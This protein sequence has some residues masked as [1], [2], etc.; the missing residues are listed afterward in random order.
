MIK[1]PQWRKR[2]CT[3]RTSQFRELQKIKNIEELSFGSVLHCLDNFPMDGHTSIGPRTLNPIIGLNKFKLYIKNIEFPTES[4]RDVAPLVTKQDDHYIC[5][6]DDRVAGLSTGYDATC[7]VVQFHSGYAG[8]SNGS[9]CR[10]LQ[11]VVPCSCSGYATET[12]FHEHALGDDHQ[13]DRS[14]S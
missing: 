11:P 8:S 3:W 9:G 14:G 2:F 5:W 6:C 1:W 12:S 7:H 4:A 10:E 13:P